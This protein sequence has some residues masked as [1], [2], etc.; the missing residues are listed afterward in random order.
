M[1]ILVFWAAG[2]MSEE[3]AVRVAIFDELGGL[4]GKTGSDQIQQTIEGMHL[5]SP[6]LIKTIWYWCFVVYGFYSS[7]CN[8]RSLGRDLSRRTQKNS[9]GVNLVYYKRSVI[10]NFYA[11]YFCAYFS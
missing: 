1:L 10:V 8:S 2:L 9:K 6:S 3:I 7:C 5:E 11:D 4:V